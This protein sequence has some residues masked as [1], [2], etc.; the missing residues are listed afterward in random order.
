MIPTIALAATLALAVSHP[1]PSTP[2]ATHA[3]PGALAA[4]RKAATA[5]LTYESGV[6]V[7]ADWVEREGDTLHTQSVLM[8]SHMIDARIVLRGDGTAASA[9]TVLLEAGE[10]P[11]NPIERSF[12]DGAVYWSDMTPSSIEQAVQRA[13]ILERPV[14][15]IPAASL[16]RDSRADLEITRIDSTDW[17]VRW[18][19][20]RYE[21]LTDASGRML[22]ASLPAFGVTIER[23]ENFTPDRYPRWAPDQAP[24]GAP[25]AVTEVKIVAPEGHVLAGT[26]SSPRGAGPFP[27]AVLITGLGPSNRNGG[28]PPWMPLRDIADAL[29]RAGVAVL[30]VDDRGV[31]ASSGDHAPSTTFDEA[32]DVATE[33]AWLRKQPHIDRGRIALVGYSEGGLIAPMVAATDSSIA[34]IVTLAGPGVPGLEVARYQIEAAIVRDT[35]IAPADREAAI[36]KELADTLTIRERSYLSID[37]LSYARRTRCPALIVQGANDLH[38]PLRS[39]ERLAWAM[40]SGGNRDVTVRFIPGVS[41]ALLPDVLG[42]NAEWVYLP[43]FLTSPDVLRA[44]TEWLSERLRPVAMSEPPRR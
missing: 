1:A 38:V 2:A 42:L 20:K 35:T 15:R 22:A 16:F 41:H 32:H 21:V 28:Q 44:M 9:S 30:R 39:A 24:P 34:A 26:L 5:F 10:A 13:R 40:R 11:T 36:A 37:P 31:G 4:P 33:V 12:G 6:L 8:Q 29:T 19:S 7:G 18:H 43:A 25:Y 17:V 27:A 14:V 3:G 23:V